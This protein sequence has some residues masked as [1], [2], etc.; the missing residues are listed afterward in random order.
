MQKKILFLGLLLLSNIVFSQNKKF[1]ILHTSDEHSALLP[2]PFADYNP[3]EKDLTEGG[4]ARLAGKIN[5]IRKSK[6]GE[7]VLLFS[8]GDIFGG[9][10]FS[11]LILK[12]Y[13]AELELMKSMKYDA[14]TVGNHEFDYG[15]E[16]LAK[17][18]KNAGY[19]KQN[20]INSSTDIIASNL[21][22]PANHPLD[23][24]KLLDNKI[25]V[26]SNG[27]KVGV[28][29]YLGEDAY[30]LITQNKNITIKK[31]ID[32]AKKQVELLKNQGADIIV[33][34]SHSGIA[35]DR[36]LAKK[37]SG[38]HLILGG[39]DHIQ[40][41]K[42]ENINNTLIFHPSYYTR[43]LGK[44]EFEFEEQTKKL[45]LGENK[46]GFLIPINDGVKEDK[47]TAK[48]IKE[49][50]QQLDKFVQH[51]TYGLF[52]EVDETVIKSDFELQN[53]NMQESAV[54][55]FITDG[56]RLVGEKIIGEKVDF[57]FQAN[58]VIR[59]GLKPGSAKWSKNQ[60][61]F[62]DIVASSCLG[63]GPDNSPGYP[64]VSVYLTEKEIF[65]A[66]EVT[67]YMAKIFGDIFFLQ[68]SG[69]RYEYNPKNATRFKV[70]FVKYPIPKF[71]AI[72]SVEQYKGEGYQQGDKDFVA[73]GN[74][75][76]KLYHVVTDY[77]IASF[78]PKI[79]EI[80]PKK[81]IVLKDKNGKP[82]Q[83]IDD[84]IVKNQSQE[85]KIWESFSVYAMHLSAKGKLPDYYS[86]TGERI[87][88]SD[89]KSRKKYLK[90]KSKKQQ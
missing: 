18:Y 17:Y 39:H 20:P 33:A 22:I 11:W 55:N 67:T 7:D 70:P 37:V 50:Q 12:D 44:L 24:I 88:K 79:G 41:D 60:L 89:V 56:M 80:I 90:L 32:I 34:L 57:A 29:G 86:K 72:Y 47:E 8:S 62:F 87:K 42:P 26:L 13:A 81:A 45:I 10:P 66:L 59:N 36:D 83:K 43:F 6:S 16:I 53:A 61:S 4:F 3:T 58:G 1:T 30:Q 71:K 21:N 84:A 65:N 78:L 48:K 35:E 76:E 85:F 74:N 77:Y 14:V 73:L 38:I 5:E 28:F 23:S 25:Y 19:H 49:Y 40:T 51:Y 27:L 31:P 15:P 52:K 75:S 69:L 2:S 68:Y 64:M 54:G 9:S 63:S 46:D 82:Y